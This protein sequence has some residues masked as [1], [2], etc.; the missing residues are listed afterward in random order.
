MSRP[1][2]LLAEPATLRF[3]EPATKGAP[4]PAFFL[5]RQTFFLF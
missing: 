5:N 2:P 4:H 3:E 1:A